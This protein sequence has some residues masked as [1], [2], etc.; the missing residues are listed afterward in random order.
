MKKQLRNKKKGFTLIELIVVV[1][2]LGVLAAVAIPRLTGNQEKAK[3]SADK[4]TFGT[5][6]SSIA[7]GVA[8]GD[9]KDGDVDVAVDATNG[10]L[11]ITGTFVA[12]YKVL[13]DGSAFKL[14]A[15]KNKTFKWTISGGKI[16]KSPTINE[17]T[18]VITN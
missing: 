11:T 4:A 10:A 6:Q 5:L 9:I 7:I 8:N 1:V 15:N 12:D 16:T 14:D 13:E 3:I 2:I 18:G 17:E